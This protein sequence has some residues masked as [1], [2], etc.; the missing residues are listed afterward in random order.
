[1]LN[2]LELYPKNQ[3]LTVE[4]LLPSICIIPAANS[5]I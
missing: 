4:I 5:N 3:R 1:M 2:S